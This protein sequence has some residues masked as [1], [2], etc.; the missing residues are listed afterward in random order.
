MEFIASMA[1]SSIDDSIGICCMLGK[2][3][4]KRLPNELERFTIVI[5]G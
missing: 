4:G 1:K 5:A 3:S 2:P